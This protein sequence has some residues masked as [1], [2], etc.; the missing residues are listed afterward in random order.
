MAD[1]RRRALVAGLLILL[2]VA[3]SL[4]CGG[5]KRK[6]TAFIDAEELYR[7]GQTQLARRDLRKAR[8]TFERIQYSVENRPQVEPLV[9]LGL[10][11]VAYYQNTTI[12]LI[13]ARAMYLDFVTLYADH[14]RAPYA[15]M[16]A[17]LCSLLQG[18][19]PSKDQSE[20]QQAIDDLRE[21]IRR[22]PNSPYAK[23]ARDLINEAENSLAEHE[24]IVG[25]FYYKRKKWT[26][27]A[28]RFQVV[29]DRYVSYPERDKILYHLG[30]ARI[31]EGKETE[32][33]LYLNQ[34]LSDYPASK[35]EKPAR[36]YLQETEGRVEP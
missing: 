25:S 18:N 33:L 27:A 15:Q 8:E 20:I 5:G 29:I 4:G 6:R 23:A 7:I 11:D 9:R 31:L 34:L 14:P 36:Q 16:Q 21:V 30:R 32:G 24:F 22:F 13:E 28:E 1:A 19:N 3:G 35:W 10:A 2:V 17:G 26:A 12:S